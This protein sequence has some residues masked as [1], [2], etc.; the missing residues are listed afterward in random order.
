MAEH[1]NVVPVVTPEFG[2]T[3]TL[4]TVGA[5]L[6]SVTTY[7]VLVAVA[8]LLSVADATQV[9]LSTV[10]TILD[11][12]CQVAPVFVAPFVAVQAYVTAKEPSFASVAVAEHVNKLDVVKPLLGLMTA[13]EM[14]GAELMTIAVDDSREAPELT[15]SVIDTL[16]R[17]VSPTERF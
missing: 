13:F 1:C 15:P 6:F 2:V 12:S 4:L 11:V 10:E 8:P 17:I 7:G 5:E 16:H 3:D 9:M 14:T